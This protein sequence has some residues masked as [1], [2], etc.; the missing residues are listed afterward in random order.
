MIL[1]LTSNK[2]ETPE[3]VTFNFIPDVPLVYRPG[4][5]LSLRLSH[6]N[7]D[8]RGTIRS[9]SLSSSPTEKV[10]AITTKAGQSSFK[11][12]LFSLP[13]GATLEARGP[14]G[15]F[16]LSDD[17]TIPVV[18]IAGG[19]GITPFR[20]MLTFAA[21]KGSLRPITLVYSNKTPEEIV[22]KEELDQLMSTVTSLRIIYTITRPEETK[23]QWSGR[24]GRIDASLIKE[25]SPLQCQY[26]ICGPVS[27]VDAM[28]EAVGSIGVSQERIRFERFTGYSG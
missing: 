17:E 5:H 23:R 20:S 24:S 10:L 28:I 1:T 11:H 4:Q 27:F 9:F 22:F 26:Y 25:V 6:E 2:K 12:A 8:E 21:D 19:I 18:L 15:G 13:I 7:P 14:G 16:V 3:V